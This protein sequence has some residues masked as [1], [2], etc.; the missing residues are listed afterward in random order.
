MIEWLNKQLND[1]TTRPHA[2]VP[3]TMTVV[4]PTII[5]THQSF[6]IAVQS[7]ARHGVPDLAHCHFQQGTTLC[8]AA[9]CSP[10]SAAQARGHRR[11]RAPAQLLADRPQV[12]ALQ[13]RGAVCMSV[14]LPHVTPVQVQGR[15]KAESADTGPA[16]GAAAALVHPNTARPP[17]PAQVSTGV[18][19]SSITAFCC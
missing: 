19:S 11:R 4:S 9:C 3:A 10:A 17:C 12:P 14:P 7:P 5:I 1:A 2:I 15:W 16:L 8:R 13:R 6:R 18:D